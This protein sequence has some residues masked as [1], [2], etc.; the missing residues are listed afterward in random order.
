MTEPSLLE[1]GDPDPVTVV[2]EGGGSVFI[3]A[4]DHAGRAF[5]R[6][7]GRLG[8][9][10]EETWRHIAWDIGIGAVGR[11]LSQK[12]DAALVLQNYS[13]LVI[14]CNRDPRVASSIPQT[15]T[16]MSTWPPRWRTRGRR[17]RPPTT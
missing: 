16:R 5:P 6:R 12:L 13:R 10:K 8:L 17:P 9:A 2:N 3:F 14:D 4:C 15:R 11:L 1:T 7:L